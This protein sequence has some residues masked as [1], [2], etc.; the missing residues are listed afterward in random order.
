M[1]VN[2]LTRNNTKP[3]G[4]RKA[5]LRILKYRGVCSRVA[6]DLGI[7][8]AHVHYVM[9]GVR[10]SRRVE[11]ALIQEISRIESENAA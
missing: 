4:P 8:R 6:K 7:S 2:N 9:T 1:T 10:S 5:F 3:K 11:Q